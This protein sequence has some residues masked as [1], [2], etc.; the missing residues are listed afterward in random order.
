MP[1]K[2]PMKT[3]STTR[4]E[5]KMETES[6]FSDRRKK[7]D[8]DSSDD[9]DDDDDDDMNSFCEDFEKSTK[10]EDEIE[11]VV[12]DLKNPHKTLAS[13]NRFLPMFIQNMVCRTIENGVQKGW[14]IDVMKV[15]FLVL[16]LA[17]LF[18]LHSFSAWIGSSTGRH[19]RGSDAINL[20]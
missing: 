15:K 16:D 17:D 8:D 20:F 5:N 10:V 9:D 18:F 4:S 3:R 11:T 12:L 19:A 7:Y 14:S 2:T 1:S 6:P 13:T